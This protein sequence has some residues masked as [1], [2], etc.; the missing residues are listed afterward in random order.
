[1]HDHQGRV[2]RMF[3]IVAENPL[4]QRGKAYVVRRTAPS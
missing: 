1:M 2:L 4:P 3:R